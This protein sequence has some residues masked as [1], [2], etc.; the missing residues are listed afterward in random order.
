M[1]NVHGLNDVTMEEVEVKMEQNEDNEE[2][3]VDWPILSTVE[4]P[5]DVRTPNGE[6]KVL[7]RLGNLVEMSEKLAN[8]EEIPFDLGVYNSALQGVPTKCSKILVK[9]RRH[10]RT[11][12]IQTEVVGVVNRH[13][14][15]GSMAD[16]HIISPRNGL[17]R[18][19]QRVRR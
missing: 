7:A 2:F 19:A 8:D 1:A 5:G 16:F 4:V 9:A 11:G 10:K 3:S 13:V 12:E 18:I 17:E 15:F 6:E 14:K